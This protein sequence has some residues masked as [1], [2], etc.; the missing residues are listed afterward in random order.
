[1]KWRRLERGMQDG[2]VDERGVLLGGGSLVGSLR[3]VGTRS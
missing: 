3:Y 1:M 2:M